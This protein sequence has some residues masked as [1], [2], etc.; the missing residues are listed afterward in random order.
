MT[1]V[2]IPLQNPS[3]AELASSPTLA[4][5]VVVLALVEAVLVGDPRRLAAGVCGARH[6]VLALLLLLLL[7]LLFV[8]LRLLLLRLLVLLLVLMPVQLLLLLLLLLLV[9]LLGE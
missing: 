2:L 4:P 5:A 9:L 1:D 8:L 7:L 6:V 3:L